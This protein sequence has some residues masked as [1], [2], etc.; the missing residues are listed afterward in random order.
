MGD[1]TKIRKMKPEDIET[2]IE[3]VRRQKKLNEE[4][5]SSFVVSEDAKTGIERYLSNALK[6]PDKYIA[7]VAECKKRVVGLIKVDILDRVC[8]DPKAE[9][10][11]VEFYVM[12]EYRRKKIGHML[13]D[14]LNSMLEKRGITLVSAEFP[15]LNLIALSFYKKNDFRDMVSI[16]GKQITKEEEESEGKGVS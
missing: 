4:F 16:Y 3:L 1:N 7:L 8:Y 10:R 13:M 9:A 5:D 2:A 14:E 15:S 11:I 6:E 12:P